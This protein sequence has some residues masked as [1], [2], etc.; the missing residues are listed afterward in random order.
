MRS[1][2]YQ[3]ILG[4]RSPPNVNN[5]WQH[6]REPWLSHARTTKSRLWGLISQ[7]AKVYRTTK[8]RFRGLTSQLEKAN[9]T[10]KVKF[11]GLIIQLAK[12]K[13]TTKSRY[14]GL[15][16]QLKKAKKKTKSWYRGSRTQLKP[17]K[18]DL[19]KWRIKLKNHTPPKWTLSRSPKN[20]T[21]ALLELLPELMNLKHTKLSN[22]SWM[23]GVQHNRRNLLVE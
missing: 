18:I 12:A 6:L 5:R 4:K 17:F 14:R 16:S 15:T 10:T 23:I 22:L 9:R 8:T 13:N 19:I 2:S 11:W 7:L 20:C 1:P 21:P 3:Q